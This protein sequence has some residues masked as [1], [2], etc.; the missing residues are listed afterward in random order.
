MCGL[1]GFVTPEG[2][3]PNYFKTYSVGG[4][5]EYCTD[6]SGCGSGVHCNAEGTCG[7][8]ESWGGALSYNSSCIPSDNRTREAGGVIPFTCAF[9]PVSVPYIENYSCGDDFVTCTETSKIAELNFSVPTI[10][11]GGSGE[12]GTNFFNLNF[13]GTLSNQ[14]TEAAAIVRAMAS[15]VWSDWGSVAP[16]IAEWAVRTVDNPEAFAYTEAQWRVV[17]SGLFPSAAYQVAVPIYRRV[18]GVGSYVLFQTVTAV[19]M[20][21]A[22]GN[23]SV[24]NTVPN[25]QGYQSYAGTA[26]VTKL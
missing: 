15:A 6:C 8:S 22:S 14:D 24:S 16:C 17:R 21:D 7:G 3:V 20:T 4:S 11:P 26:T 23:L 9:N 1:Q 13:E 19:V 12:C 2:Q 18:F 25:A 5:L 10:C